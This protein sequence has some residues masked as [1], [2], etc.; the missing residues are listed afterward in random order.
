MVA[1]KIKNFGGMIPIVDDR[2]LPDNQAALSVNTWLYSGALEAFRVPTPIHDLVNLS[3]KC[4]Y[5]IPT[6]GYSKDNMPDAV[7]LEFEALNVDVV[8]SPVVADEFERIYYVTDKSVDAN[9][10]P[11]YNTK[12]R[13]IAGSAAYKLGIPTPASAPMV[14]GADI[15]FAAG[16]V[17]AASPL[18]TTIRNFDATMYYARGYGVDNKTFQTEMFLDDKAYERMGEVIFTSSV[19]GSTEKDN[20][21]AVS[22]IQANLFKITFYDTEM[23][24]TTTV[25]ASRV[26]VS[27]TGVFTKGTPITPEGNYVGLGVPQT[28]AYAYTWVS[29][30]GEE[31][32]PSIPT[33]ADGWSG[34]PWTIF[35]TPPTAD[36]LANRNLSKVRIYRT[37]TAA[38]G[39]TTF[40]FVTELDIGTTKFVDDITDDVAS[41]NE[42]LASTYWSEPPA[43]MLGIV[44]MP[45][46]IMAGFFNNEIWFSEPYRPH[47]WPTPYALAVEFP[48]VGLGVLG[49]T[50]LVLTNGAPYACSGVNP[51]AMSLSKMATFEPCMS[52]GSIVSTPSGVV[53]ATP[54]GLGLATAAGVQILTRNIV[55]KDHWADLALIDTLRAGVL[56]GGYYCWGSPRYGC[57]YDGAFD[58]DN[59]ELY[60]YTGGYTGAFFDVQNQRVSWSKL[61]NSV[62]TVNTF[63]DMWTGEIMTIEGGKV[64]WHDISSI[65]EHLTFQWKS[66]V[67]QTPNNRNFGAARVYFSP[68]PEDGAALIFKFYADGVLKSTRT[69]AK[70]GDIIRLPSGY[71]AS[72]F[73]IEL[74]GNALVYS[75]E[76]ANAAKELISV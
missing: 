14:T 20:V 3:A 22:D 46:G 25:D 49:Q 6:A 1:I 15:T 34:D 62:P 47:A 48:I 17:M 12:A 31:G 56:N 58:N 69:I 74:S 63:T 42:I 70:S 75:V 2:L 68:I 24:Y 72:Y 13:A 73:Q 40:F 29:A 39:A 21:P 45:N 66:K 8:K 50:L 76:V 53:Y 57:F 7:W 59:F 27:D 23:R 19:V 33:V 5:R 71:K 11:M 10:V 9:A 18:R 61:T 52:R 55:S 54:N 16:Y 30:Y 65:R 44:A 26:I 36:N 64:Y 38:G 35:L 60:D 4:I 41:A 28:R 67:F 37:V 32:P 51:A 43:E